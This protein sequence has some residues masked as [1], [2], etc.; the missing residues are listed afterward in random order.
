MPTV[1]PWAALAE[2]LLGPA[3]LTTDEVAR[4]AGIDPARARQLWQSLG[5]PPVATDER[6]FTRADVAVLAGVRELIE[7][8]ETEPETVLQLT[9]VLGQSLARIADAHLTATAVHIEELRGSAELDAAAVDAIIARVEAVAPRLEQALGYVWRRH[10]LAL[11]R[12]IAARP[13]T[14][15]RSVSVG[16][17]DLVGFTTLSRALDP[18]AL[19]AVVD[20]FES[21]AYERIPARGGRIVK[22]IGDEVMFAAD[23]PADGAEIALQ[24]AE[25]YANDP[26]VPNIRVG[27]ARGPVLAWEGDLF[28][29][30]V[31]LASRLVD[32]ARPGTVLMSENLGQELRADARFTLRHLRPL[33]LKGFGPTRAWVLR[34][35]A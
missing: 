26:G 8:F 21:I 18:K 27:L 32:F 17:A 2:R 28:G 9:R 13:E 4:L 35:A 23:D 11:L 33:P 20:R 25:S 19:A 7:L 6:V 3:E 30:T 10:L 31:N 29:P 24:L 14:T 22:L 34:R 12:R 5:F 15:D 1:D 16:F